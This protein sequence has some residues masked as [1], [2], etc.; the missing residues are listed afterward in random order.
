MAVLG[1]LLLF[2]PSSPQLP[3]PSTWILQTPGLLHVISVSLEEPPLPNLKTQSEHFLLCEAINPLKQTRP[4]MSLLCLYLS[5]IMAFN[6]PDCN[7]CLKGD[8]CLIHLLCATNY[9]SGYVYGLRGNC[10]WTAAI[11]RNVLPGSMPTGKSSGENQS[12]PG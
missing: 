7:E 6:T 12:P 11:H 5:N 8:Q 10:S 9:H 3:V 2:S 1:M 4:L